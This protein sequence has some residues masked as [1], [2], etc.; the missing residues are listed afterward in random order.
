MS[1]TTSKE[2]QGEVEVR[3]LIERFA[4]LPRG[5]SG[6]LRTGAPAE[7]QREALAVWRR[8][9]ETR[10]SF[11]KQIGVSG[12]TITNWERAC[13]KR[14]KPSRP[15]APSKAT[16]EPVFKQV[17]VVAEPTVAKSEQMF[18]LELGRGARVTGLS[19]NDMARLLA[20]GGRER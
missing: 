16:K 2:N 15:Q 4:A 14:A 19:F 11:S 6:R 9:G 17:A 10:E 5:R 8:T 3:S 18:V 20:L 1:T 7:L 13:R 12:T